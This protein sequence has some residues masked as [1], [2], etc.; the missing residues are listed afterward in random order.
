MSKSAEIIAFEKRLEDSA[1]RQAAWIAAGRGHLFQPG[2]TAMPTDPPPAPA[3]AKPKAGNRAYDHLFSGT[4]AAST[5]NTI[6]RGGRVQEASTP[7]A[8][9]PDPAHDHLFGVK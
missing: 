4:P 5:L 6:L 3:P 9:R 7:A 2:S 8:T 1:A